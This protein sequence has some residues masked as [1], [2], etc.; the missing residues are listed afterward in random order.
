MPF[1]DY[2]K[3]VPCLETECLLLRPF[4]REDMETYLTFMRNP[5]VHRFLGG[6]VTVFDGEPHITN[7]LNNINGRLLKSKA[8]LTWCVELK[9]ENRVIG[10][11]DL[12]GFVK[13]SMAELSYYFA[14]EYW[15][16]AL[17]PRL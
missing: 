14:E 12:G 1:N 2:F 10:R 9:S 3:E 6:G 4:R 7:W 11:T 16:R 5:E 13:K 17:P 8:V 15:G